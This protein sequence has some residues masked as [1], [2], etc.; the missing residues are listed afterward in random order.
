M[1]A[2]H[3]SFATTILARG[4]NFV[5]H[6]PFA[7]EGYICLA[8]QV[9]VVASAV[10]GETGRLATISERLSAHRAG[11]FGGLRVAAFCEGGQAL[12]VSI[13]VTSL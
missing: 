8:V 13:A 7:V 1:Q 2:G 3:A 10:E 6:V 4:F 5:L 9:Q 12:H 11:F